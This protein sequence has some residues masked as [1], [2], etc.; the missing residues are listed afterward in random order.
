M[1]SL[2]ALVRSERPSAIRSTWLVIASSIA[3]RVSARRSR[4]SSSAAL[5]RLRLSPSLT[6]KSAVR[7][8]SMAEVEATRSVKSAPIRAL[9][10]SSS[11]LTCCLPSVNVCAISLVRSISV[12]LICLAR[13]S[14][15]ALSF[16]VPVSSAWAR[17]SNCESRDWPRSSSVRSMS[18]RR[19]SNSS[20]SERAELPSSEIMPVVR[21]SSICESERVAW[22]V[23]SVSEAMRVSSRFAI[24]SPEVEMRSEM[25]STRRSRAS[26]SEEPLWFIRSISDAPLSAIVPESCPETSTMFL[27]MTSLAAE[28]SSFSVS[29]APAMDARTRS[30]WLTTASRSLPRPSTSARMRVS[31]SE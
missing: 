9:V 27:R 29:C 8:S 3:C 1:S 23:A 15:A 13:A 21:S 22:S 11:T 4:S 31:F 2:S 25:V 26:L 10:S 24:A 17:V 12:S 14:S 16:S 7:V 19:V 5:M 18:R 28:S 20:E 30:A 6:E